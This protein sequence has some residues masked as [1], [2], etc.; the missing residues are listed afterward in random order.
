[1]KKINVKQAKD[2]KKYQDVIVTQDKDDPTLE[3]INTGE[4]TY[5]VTAW[6]LDERFKIV[7]DKIYKRIQG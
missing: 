6:A 4:E 7:K 2:I 3:I 5:T 1:M